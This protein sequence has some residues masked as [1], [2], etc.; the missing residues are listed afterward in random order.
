MS[1]SNAASSGRATVKAIF[2]GTPA[3]AVPVLSSLLDAGHEIVGVYTRPDRPSGR[4]KRLL[5]PA[6]KQFA[7]QRGLPVFQPK[8]L[9]SDR[10]HEQMAGLGAQV[11][12]V[13][14]YGVMLPSPTLEL[15]PMGCLNIH[16]SLLPKYRG[17]S[18]V[19]SAILNGDQSTGVT[20]I[21]LDEG[22]DTGPIIAARGTQ[23]GARENAE[24]L[25]VR[26]FEMG[27]SLLV[28]VL[29]EWAAGGI[30][31]EGQDG[32]A[33]TTT[34]RLSKEDGEIDWSLAAVV[35]ERQVRAYQPWPGSFSRLKGK[36]LKVIEADAV[37]SE[38]TTPGRVVSLPGAG[39]GI[40][41]GDGV[42]AVHRLQLEGRSAVDADE[43]LSGYP[44][45]VG[46]SVG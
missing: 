36:L 39:V 2:M 31:S 42:L 33:A 25:T 7:Q 12:F 20:I 37:A 22:M 15:P 1:R 30:E 44:N 35:I 34:K 10:A 9:R 3:F 23:I 45:A 17:P 6:V 43:F 29:P 19:S 5:A 24:E 27:A 11:I 21:K 14:A 41:T 40:T 18:P 8:S 4:G 16:P 13:A 38:S 28:E 46:E 26:L 32:S